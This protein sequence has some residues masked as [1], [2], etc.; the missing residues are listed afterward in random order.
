M[1][2]SDFGSAQSYHHG[3]VKEELINHALKWV[4]TE[5]VDS[6]SLRNLAK[7]V[8]IT[9]P[10]VY[11]HFA[12]K[13]ALIHTVKMRALE[14]F[15]AYFDARC[16]SVQ[17]PEEELVE[18]C[19][20][21]YHYSREFPSRFN[22]IFGTTLP[23]AYASEEDLPVVS[24]CFSR[25]KELVG[26]IHRKLRIPKNDHA[27]VS[28]TLLLWSQLHGLVNLKNA[29]TIGVVASYLQWPASCALEEDDE[30]EIL[31]RNQIEA[32]VRSM[33]NSAA[34]TR[35]PSPGEQGNS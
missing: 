28:H 21:Y 4:E 24:H 27:L 20:A 32:L 33:A 7:H 35:Y 22:F 16:S 19:F 12:D 6:L 8:G 11:N 1:L 14:Q 2:A 31:I 29:G 26:E 15:N 10:A 13:N 17:D 9:P 5:G 30:V 34:L 25:A 18:M 3:N 23:M